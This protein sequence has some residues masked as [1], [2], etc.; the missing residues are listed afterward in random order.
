MPIGNIALSGRRGET[1][2]IRYQKKQ[3]RLA[4]EAADRR[5]EESR[6]AAARGDREVEILARERGKEHPPGYTPEGYRAKMRARHGP[7]W[8]KRLWSDR[9]A[10]IRQQAAPGE[11]V[12][13]EEANRL[14]AAMEAKHRGIVAKLKYLFAKRKRP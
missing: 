3:Y 8:F 13:Q 2:R 4:R 7:S 14:M 5:I 1:A 12:Q 9:A 10:E 6:A 11:Q